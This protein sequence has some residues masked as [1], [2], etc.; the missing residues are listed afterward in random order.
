M[1]NVEKILKL[2]S[3][4]L[5]S[6]EIA[7]KINEEAEEGAEVI[8]HQAVTKIINQEKAKDSGDGSDKNEPGYAGVGTIIPEKPMKKTSMET[9]KV[10]LDRHKKAGTPYGRQPGQVTKLTT[11]ELRVLINANW[12]PDMVKEKHGLDAEGLAKVVHKLSK[13]EL[14]DVL[15]KF[16]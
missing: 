6:G 7:K 11:E 2:S 16:A 3:E 1:P 13:E 14:R 9:A 8:T 12:T 4:G 15:I 5:R 10:Y